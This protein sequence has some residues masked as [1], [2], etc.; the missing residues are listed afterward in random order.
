MSTDTD[1]L[2]K[3]ALSLF[4]SDYFSIDLA[5]GDRGRIAI[6]SQ[7]IS[8]SQVVLTTLP[9]ASVICEEW[10][11]DR[12]TCHYCFKFD[13]FKKLKSRCQLYNS[14]R[15]QNCKSVYCSEECK[16]LDWDSG[17]SISCGYTILF[18]S[19]IFYQKKGL[20]KQGRRNE[21]GGCDA[22]KFRDKRIEWDIPSEYLDE[23][24]PEE[25]ERD[26]AR[27]VI[28]VLA[29]KYLEGNRHST[30]P[31]GSESC[32]GN[33]D[34]KS[35]LQL[36]NNEEIFEKNPKN[37]ASIMKLKLLYQYLRFKV[38]ISPQILGDS[39]SLFRDVVFREIANSFGIWDTSD[40]MTSSELLGYAIYPHASY[41]NHSCRPNLKRFSRGR[42]LEFISQADIEIGTELNIAYGYIDESVDHRRNR[43]HEKFFFWCQ[44]QLC[45]EM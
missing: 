3:N 15:K 18:E 32:D 30:P 13:H 28:N 21:E 11:G 24:Y 44:C 5:G 19:R 16:K 1:I 31:S 37:S 6:A 4:I 39:S 23:Y 8:K 29:K 34:W 42:F 45:R 9:Y 36:Q 35:M 12:K 43:L 7:N 25:V 2:D 26:T 22:E 38:G 33:L 40:A 14:T 17:H 10:L 27:F 41:F 20:M